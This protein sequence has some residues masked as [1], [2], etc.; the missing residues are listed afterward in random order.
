V[1]ELSE[2][3]AAVQALAR[4]S[5]LLERALPTL[6]LA[7]FR[8]LSAVAEGEARASRLAT[9]LALGKPAISSTV[10]SLVRRGLLARTVPEVDQRAVDLALTPAGEAVRADAERTLVG[11][12]TELA[13][14]TGEPDTVLRS[15]AALGAAIERLHVSVEPRRGRGT[16][17]DAAEA[18]R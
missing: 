10:D 16:R 13:G 14:D 15:L 1:I 11:I 9:R 6:S 17:S 4:A 3:L 5:R 7:D 2:R 8:V 12:V 18:A